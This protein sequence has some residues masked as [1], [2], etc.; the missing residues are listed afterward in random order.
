M[1]D[2]EYFD[3]LEKNRVEMVPQGKIEDSI[4][5]GHGDIFDFCMK[6]K[7]FKEEYE[8]SGNKNTYEE[9][10]K[11]FIGYLFE[12]KS[13]PRIKYYYIKNGDHTLTL[14]DMEDA[15]NLYKKYVNNDMEALAKIDEANEKA[16]EVDEKVKIYKEHKEE[17]DAMIKKEEQLKA[18]KDN[19]VSAEEADLINYHNMY[20]SQEMIEEYKLKKGVILE[21]KGGVVY[22]DAKNAIY[23]NGNFQ[24]VL[25]D[26][27]SGRAVTKKLFDK[28]IETRKKS[29]NNEE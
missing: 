20:L 8:K 15:F 16:K 19:A 21:L 29:I 10:I 28:L 12:N 7:G 24:I 23:V 1:T 13:N 5:T 18:L 25:V 9:V 27:K 2:K 26:D 4:E 6:D 17:I 14:M 22:D 11:K 3:E